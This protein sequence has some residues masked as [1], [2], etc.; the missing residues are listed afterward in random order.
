M[1]LPRE[2]VAGF[3]LVALVTLAAIPQARA[4]DL[5]WPLDSLLK[6]E[7]IVVAKVVKVEP[8]D[9]LRFARLEVIERWKG[10]AP[11]DLW[12][13]ASPT[14]QCDHSWAEEGERA[15]FFLF[16]VQD[17]PRLK[18]SLDAGIPDA[19]MKAG[20]TGPVF[21]MWGQGNGRF[22]LRKRDGVTYAEAY[23]GVVAPDSLK[24]LPA[25]PSGTENDKDLAY[26]W[27][28]ELTELRRHVIY[29]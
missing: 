14:W 24:K 11:D 13:V 29:R 9:P 6:A 10:H 23:D 7:L 27:W 18:G 2:R 17:N 4:D 20:H 21:K 12:V 22:V 26:L 3:L 1:G 8:G 25:Q 28:V 5:A 16:N 15:V 19:W